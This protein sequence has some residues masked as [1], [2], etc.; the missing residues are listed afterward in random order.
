VQPTAT[1][2][3]RKN[4]ERALYRKLRFKVRSIA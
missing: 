2:V 3:T 4:R 1:S